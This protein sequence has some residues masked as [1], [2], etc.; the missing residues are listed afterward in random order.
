MY[1]FMVTI[2]FVLLEEALVT[3]SLE[4]F[5]FEV[6][7]AYEFYIRVLLLAGIAFRRSVVV[8]FRE[9]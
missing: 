4:V 8:R 5:A 3:C 2:S 6:V 9:R 7:V 1:D